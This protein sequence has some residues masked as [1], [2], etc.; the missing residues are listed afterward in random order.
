MLCATVSYFLLDIFISTL[1]LFIVVYSA[2]LFAVILGW[3]GVAP[4]GCLPDRLRGRGATGARP[5]VLAGRQAREPPRSP[6]PAPPLCGD[7]SVPLSRQLGVEAARRGGLD[8]PQ[9]HT[10]LMRR[11]EPGRRATQKG[12]VGRGVTRAHFLIYVGGEARADRWAL[13]PVATT[14]PALSG[15]RTGA[16]VR[17][18]ILEVGS[19]NSGI[20]GCID[21]SGVG[22]RPSNMV[23]S[24]G[25]CHFGCRT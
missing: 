7:P 3:T 22:F 14:S 1:G 21:G 18:T 12:K 23:C 19:G 16:S 13:A 9:Y 8:A 24:H 4:P 25:P 5:A 15:G 17:G 2:F 11:R 6:A 10:P 20:S